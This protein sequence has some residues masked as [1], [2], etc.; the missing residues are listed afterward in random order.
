MST[1][2]FCPRCHRPVVRVEKVPTV[3]PVL[4]HECLLSLDDS[5]AEDL[6]QALDRKVVRVLTAPGWKSA[7]MLNPD[8]SKNISFGCPWCRKGRV[9]LF[10]G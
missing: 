7:I 1:P 6:V 5:E 4:D 3:P 10:K 2:E 9:R 8:T